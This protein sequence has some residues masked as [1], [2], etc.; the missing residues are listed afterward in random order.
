MGAD[1]S[2]GT[3]RGVKKLRKTRGKTRRRSEP[4]GLV[5]SES[6]AE[7]AKLTEESGGRSKTE[8]GVSIAVVVF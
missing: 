4:P 6:E 5:D 1:H 8:G 3:E 2:A 7:P